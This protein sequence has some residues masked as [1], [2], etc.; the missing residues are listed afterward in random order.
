[1][2]LYVLERGIYDDTLGYVS[3]GS[4]LDAPKQF[5][6]R[7][8]STMKEI[9]ELPPRA[10]DTLPPKVIKVQNPQVKTKPVVTK[11][12]AEPSNPTNSPQVPEK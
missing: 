11:E 8:G 5:V 10:A 6:E 3:R 1:M 12:S 7:Y 4:F 9:P 2:A